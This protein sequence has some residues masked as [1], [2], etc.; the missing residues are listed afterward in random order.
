MAASLLSILAR[1]GIAVGGV[2]VF[3]NNCLYDVD[4]GQGAVLFDRFQGGVMPDVKT[5][6]THFLVPWVQ[7]PYV[8]DIRTR[9]KMINSETGTKDM[10]QVQIVLRVLTRPDVD[11]LPDIYKRLGLDFDQ[12]VIPSI[13]NEVLK[14]VVAQYNAD[15]LLTQR[16][17]IS[18]EIRTQLQERA[19]EFN[20]ILDDVSMTHLT[21]GTDFTKAIEMK[22]VAQQ[23]AERS[24]FVVMRREEEK[25]AA[26]IRAEGESEAAKLISDSLR[27]NGN[28]MIEV[29]RID[30]AVQIA[31][32]LSRSRNI[33]YLPS[34][35]GGGGSNVL[36]GI[37]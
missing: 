2:S 13:G 3:A 23:E 37:K 29:N 33:T 28:G 7:K 35:S 9:P 31:E 17:K 1:G 19:A 11:K 15:Q 30:A 8:M 25:K 10:Q 20:I 14:S 34:S 18:R 24:K 26:I 16:E 27:N 4:G 22:Q 36:L 12:R 21:F 5:E 6:G 32:S